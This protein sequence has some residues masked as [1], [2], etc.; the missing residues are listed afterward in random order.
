MPQVARYCDIEE[1]I[2]VSSVKTKYLEDTKL[3]IE[4]AE[5]MGKNVGIRND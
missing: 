1:S 3:R 5:N 4:E 2:R